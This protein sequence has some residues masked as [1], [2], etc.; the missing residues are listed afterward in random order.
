MVR[1]AT[2]IWDRRARSSPS[3]A[4]HNKKMADSA[5]VN[6]AL[7]PGVIIELE[8]VAEWLRSADANFQTTNDIKICNNAGGLAA[9]TSGLL[10]K[11]TVTEV[12]NGPVESRVTAIHFDCPTIV[13]VD[14]GWIV[15]LIP[16]HVVE[17]P[18]ILGEI[19]LSPNSYIHLSEKA[20]VSGDFFGLLLL[21][22]FD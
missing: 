17:E 3:V 13:P 14:A 18:V 5:I 20:S 22:R 15:D 9:V 10:E 2:Y 7:P 1:V 21:F 11:F 8:K 4:P 16:V 19:P 6:K 12:K